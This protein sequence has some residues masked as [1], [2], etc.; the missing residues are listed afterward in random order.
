MQIAEEFD[1]LPLSCF[2]FNEFDR[3]L[4]RKKNMG[5]KYL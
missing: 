5:K 4:G 3:A 1:K 2:G